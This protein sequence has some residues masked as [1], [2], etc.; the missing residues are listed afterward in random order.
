MQRSVFA[1]FVL[2][3]LHADSPSGDGRLQVL[4]GPNGRG[5]RRGR[6]RRRGAERLREVQ[7]RRR[8]P[9]GPGRAVGSPAP[10]PIHG[11]RDLQR[12]GDQGSA[13]PGRG[14]D[15][16]RER[17]PL[18]A[19]GRLPGARRDHGGAPAPPHRRI[20]LPRQPGP[21]AAPR[22]ERHLLRLR[23][24]AHRLLDHRAG[25]HR[26]DRVGP[27]RGP[28]F[29]DRGGGWH[30][31]VQEASRGR[32]TEDGGHPPQP[33]A[34]HRHRPGARQA[35]RLPQ[36][37]GP[38]GRA[39][40]GAEGAGPGAGASRGRGPLAGVDGGAARGRGPARAGAGRG[41]RDLGASRPDRP[42]P[43]GR[44]RAAGGAR[45]LA[46]A[47]HR[48]GARAGE[49]G[50]GVGGLHGGRRAGTRPDRG[51][52]ARP[53][54]R[55]RGP[56]DPGRRPFGRAGRAPPAAG[57]A[58]QPL[59]DR[60]GPALRA[61]GRAPRGG[62]RGGLGRRRGGGGPIQRG[63]RAR[64]RHRPPQRPRPGGA[65]ARRSPV[66]A[67]AR[68]HGDRRAGLPGHH[69]RRFPPGARREAGEDPAAEAP[70]RGATRRAG[71]AARPHP[72]RVHPERGPAD[73]AARGALRP[74]RPAPVASGGAAQLRGLW[75]RR[76][77][78]DDPGPRRRG[79][80]GRRDGA[81]PT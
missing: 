58:G 59:G 79:G 8:H 70:P 69:P 10:R 33:G 75:P 74:A 36:P 20:G 22:R 9:L 7:R 53:G 76:A 30:H 42:G 56:Q 35:A 32:R 29:G 5:L 19:S 43:R 68:P 55:G 52:L 37:P 14:D 45:A 66:P 23:R 18:R 2:S 77:Q 80:R 72:L 16:L 44:P 60:R 57:R 25:A 3:R 26:P 4:H 67:G 54:L 73:H 64:P 46:A 81:R 39:L 28:P 48:A 78:P 40:P 71:G 34:G 47:A 13:L 24:G 21:G 17:P 27:G 61:R 51:A 41:V 6:D 1:V 63:R 49:P 31:Q 50:T 38:E 62:R 15:H 11:G 12:I 65:A